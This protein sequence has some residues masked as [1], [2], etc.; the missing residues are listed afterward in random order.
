MWPLPSV[1]S[2]LALS[3]V[4]SLSLLSLG[5]AQPPQL[6][7]PTCT[8]GAYVNDLTP[9]YRFFAP[10]SY[11]AGTDPFLF[12]VNTTVA[13]GAVLH[14]STSRVACQGAHFAI[15]LYSSTNYLSSN[16]NGATFTQVASTG[17]VVVYGSQTAGTNASSLFL[18]FTAPVSLQNA[19]GLSYHLLLGV[20]DTR[21]VICGNSTDVDPNVVVDPFYTYA[22]SLTL[23]PAFTTAYIGQHFDMDVVTCSFTPTPLTPPS[24]SCFPASSSSSTGNGAAYSDPFSSS[25][26]SVSLAPSAAS[27]STAIGQGYSDPR[28]LGFWGQNQ[29]VGGLG[30]SVYSLLL[31][32]WVLVNARFVLLEAEDIHCPAQLTTYCVAEKGTYFGEAGVLS[33]NG[34]RLE[35][36]AGAAEHGFTKVTLNGVDLLPRAVL[37]Q[38]AATKAS[39]SSSLSSMS[40]VGRVRGAAES[41]AYDGISVQLHSVSSLTVTVGVYVIRLDVVDLY[42]DFTSVNTHC[43]RCLLDEVRPTGLLG[44]THDGGVEHS[45]SEEEVDKYREQRG[46]L[47]GCQFNLPHANMPTPCTH[48]KDTQT[49]GEAQGRH[50]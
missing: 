35:V 11:L 14:L 17:D 29:Y 36:V 33:A 44:R 32:S 7:Y 41:P 31:D 13:Y 39:L 38:A 1:M 25:A 42:L 43:W 49:A 19:T 6:M 48:S 45:T 12:S 4:L 21:F 2:W 27:S 10:T 16:G 28:I 30:G 24:A 23:P 22:N 47:L 15:G 34:D 46:D 37:Q 18:R 3:F 26:A 9:T 20:N 5:V 8:T 50:M 40:S